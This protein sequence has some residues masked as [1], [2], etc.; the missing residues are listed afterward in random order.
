V[1]TS[2]TQPAG[3]NPSLGGTSSSGIATGGAK[4]TGGTTATGGFKATGGTTA[5]GGFKATGGTT[6]TGGSKATGGT[7]ATGGSKATGG[8]TATGGTAATGGGSSCPF[9]TTFKWKDNGGSIANPAN[10]WASIK[11]FTNVVYNGQHIIY[12]STHDTG[13]TYGSAAMAPFTDWSQAATATQTKM[14][15][16]TVAPE[17]MYFTPKNTWILSYQWCSAKFCYMTSSDP[18]KASSWT[19]VK[20]LFNGTISNSG[21][22]PIDQ[23]VICDSKNCYLFFAGD[24][25]SIYRSSM[26]IGSFP[27][28]FGAATTIMTDTQSNLFEAVEVYTVKGTGKY[29]MIVEAMGSG[30]RYFRA[31]SATSLDGNWTAISGAATEATPFAGKKNVTFTTAWTN[32]ISHGDIVRSHDETRTIDP[33]N[34]QMIYQGYSPSFSGDYDLKPYRLGLLTFTK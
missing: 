17:L 33:C 9:P 3:G 16:S 24:N 28:T 30:G 8:T 4:A 21:T 6:A 11:D 12:M 26:A 32:D 22:G 5:T 34:L 20:P 19:G 2:N 31:F 10:G 15:T 13:T 23:V 25:G 29:L 1:N 14:T 18:T 27:G 7:T